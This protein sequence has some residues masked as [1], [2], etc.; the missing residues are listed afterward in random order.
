MGQMRGRTTGTVD[1][2]LCK[3]FLLN[4]PGQI[5]ETHNV[6]LLN[7]VIQCIF[8]LI[9]NVEREFILDYHTEMVDCALKYLSKRDRRIE[10]RRS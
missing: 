2:Y 8:D 3:V 4:E 5:R 10:I 9:E 1:T 6:T 7:G